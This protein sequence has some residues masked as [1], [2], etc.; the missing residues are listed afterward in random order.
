M[1]LF[2][3]HKLILQTHVH[4]NPVGLDIWFLVGPFVYFDTSCVRTAKTLV[5]LCG[6]AGSPE[7]SLVAYVISTIISW[8]GSNLVL[9]K[10]CSFIKNSGQRFSCIPDWNFLSDWRC[11]TWRG[12]CKTTLIQ[13]S[14][15]KSYVC[16]DIILH[17]DDRKWRRNG[18][19]C[20]PWSDLGL[21]CLQFAQTYMSENLGSLRY[22][23]LT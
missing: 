17:H 5:R 11:L 7:L 15:A 19:Q 1:V 4:S 22:V 21:H 2:V 8:A 6:W 3:L 23:I 12:G 10:N 9:T 13:H 14:H 20:R 18:K 16:F